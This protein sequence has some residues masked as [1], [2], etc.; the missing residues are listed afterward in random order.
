MLTDACLSATKGEEKSFHCCGRRVKLVQAY[1]SV[2]KLHYSS[3][4]HRGGPAKASFVGKIQEAVLHTCGSPVKLM[5][6][7]L[8]IGKLHYS[9]FNHYRGPAKA[10]KGG[11]NYRKDRESSFHTC[12]SPVKLVQLCLGVW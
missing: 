7:Y 1:L 11:F 6:A 2:G 8:S 4:N 10:V 5:Q 3:F 12:G 9:R